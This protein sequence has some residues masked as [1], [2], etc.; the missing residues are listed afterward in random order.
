MSST[1]GQ[2][3]LSQSKPPRGYSKPKSQR[4]P[5][6]G[7]LRQLASLQRSLT[8]FLDVI[9]AEAKQLDASSS[10]AHEIVE[11]IRSLVKRRV[12]CSGGP[13]DPSVYQDNHSAFEEARTAEND[14]HEM[15]VYALERYQRRQVSDLDVSESDSD[16]S[17][18]VRRRREYISTLFAFQAQVKAII[19][20]LRERSSSS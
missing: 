4:S 13:L 12:F 14:G 15:Y 6:T 9:D 11:N 19:D 7:P 16:R 20:Y 1:Q 3:E 10:D 17:A 5:A 8:R 18:L 2:A